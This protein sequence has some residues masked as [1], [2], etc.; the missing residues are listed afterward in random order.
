MLMVSRKSN[1][2]RI[3]LSFADALP[4]RPIYVTCAIRLSP[5]T[6]LCS[7]MTTSVTKLRIERNS[8]NILSFTFKYASTELYLFIKKSWILVSLERVLPVENNP[9]TEKKSFLER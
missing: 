6:Y 8:F 1:Y 7:S 2:C 5:F 4:Y 3:F 9:E